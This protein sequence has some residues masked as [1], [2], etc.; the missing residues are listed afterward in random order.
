MSAH[1]TRRRFLHLAATSAL[2]FDSLAVPRHVVQ[3]RFRTPKANIPQTP[4]ERTRILHGIRDYVAEHN[5]VP[6]LPMAQL[7]E[8]ADKLVTLLRF[9]LRYDADGRRLVM[10]IY[11][12]LRG[13]R[14]WTVGT[15]AACATRKPAKAPNERQSRGLCG[16]V[17]LKAK[18]MKTAEL[19]TTSGQRP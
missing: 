6:P 18:M 10:L 17:K 12:G 8:H 1:P 7:K 4:F 11:S 5:P 3:Q 16:C 2:T 13:G 9:V 19:S 15:V 14:W